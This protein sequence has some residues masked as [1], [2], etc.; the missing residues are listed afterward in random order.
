MEQWSHIRES[1]AKRSAYRQKTGSQGDSFEESETEEPVITGEDFSWVDD[2]LLDLEP[3]DT[4]T[5]APLTGISPLTS[6]RLHYPCRVSRRLLLPWVQFLSLRL[7]L[8]SFS[9]RHTRCLRHSHRTFLLQ[10]MHH[11]QLLVDN[12]SRKEW[13]LCHSHN[14]RGLSQ[15]Q[16]SYRLL[17]HN[18]L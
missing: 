11:T 2:T 8:H 12:R 14:H 17:G 13:L 4:G 3:K 5:S 15:Q 9:G 7:T 10:D 1:F 6:P 16:R 18:S